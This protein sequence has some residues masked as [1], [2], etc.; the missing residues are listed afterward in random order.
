[1]G[2][3]F[4]MR[5][6]LGRQDERKMSGRWPRSH[7]PLIYGADRGRVTR[8]FRRLPIR[9]RL[10]IAFAGV[11]G[12]LLLAGGAVLFAQFE[13]YLDE[14]IDSDLNAR[15]ADAVAL[16]SDNGAPVLVRSGER[17]AQVYD[18]RGGV[19]ASTRR[20]GRVRLLTAAEARRAAGERVHLSRVDTPAGPTRVLAQTVEA[21]GRRLTVAVAESMQRRDSALGHL[22]DLL[23]LI[24]PVALLLATWAGYQVAGA[25]LRPVEQ[26]RRRAQGITERDIAER[27]PVP[28]TSDEIEALGRTLNELLERLDCALRRERRMLADASHELRTPLTVLRAEVQLALR[29]PRDAGELH[30]ALESVA[31]QSERLSHLAEDL[32][33]LARADDGRLPIRGE[34]LAA[35]DLL[36]AAARRAAA[37]A[38]AAGRTLAVRGA[39]EAVLLAD[40]D[41]A[42]QALDNL[43]ANALAHGGGDVELAARRVDGRVELHVT[44]HGAGFEDELLGRAFER[45]S[46]GDPARAGEGTGLGLAIVAAIAEAHDGDAA[47]SNLP[48]GGADVWISLPAS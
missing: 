31:R 29:R 23:F 10:T 41:R 45:F 6:R 48:G 39:L 32:L 43:V 44:D 9:I 40:P 18:R 8:G 1:M 36:D 37:A 4:G 42:A 2:D 16:V 28:A 13:G 12:T 3:M 21:P 15:T 38:R 27:L 33:V 11:L 17:L 47:A 20:L 35:G 7:D 5:P 22:R 26:M 24:G 34:P 30:A 14:I 25:A 19:V 46:R